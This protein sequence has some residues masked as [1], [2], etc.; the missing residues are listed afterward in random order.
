MVIYLSV[1]KKFLELELHA[2]HS[3][4]QLITYEL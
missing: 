4:E 3:Y 1:L 2:I